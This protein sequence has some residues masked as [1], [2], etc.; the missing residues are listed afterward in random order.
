MSATTRVNVLT[1]RRKF[2]PIRPN[3]VG[4]HPAT[5]A[6]DMLGVIEGEMEETLDGFARSPI[7]IGPK[8][9]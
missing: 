1:M 5:L 7:A 6:P 2:L 4:A 3:A 8:V 9:G